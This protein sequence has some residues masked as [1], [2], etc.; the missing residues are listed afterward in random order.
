MSIVYLLVCLYV[1][2]AIK[3]EGGD[4]E[5]IQLSV[6]TPTRKGGKA[7]GKYDVLGGEIQSYAW[8]NTYFLMALSSFREEKRGV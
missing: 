5:N 7:K 2:K 1:F 6:D 4:S 8:Q 3:D